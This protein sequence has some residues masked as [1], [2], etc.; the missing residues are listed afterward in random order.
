VGHGIQASMLTA[1][2]FGE[3]HPVASNDTPAGCAEK[4]RVTVE[5]KGQK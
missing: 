4:R 1:E 2:R 3:E 5:F